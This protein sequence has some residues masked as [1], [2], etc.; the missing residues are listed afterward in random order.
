MF[1][2]ICSRSRHFLVILALKPSKPYS[3]C[4]CRILAIFET[5]HFELHH[6]FKIKRCV[7]HLTCTVPASP[8]SAAIIRSR[9]MIS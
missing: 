5:I 6:L 1:R 3:A 9:T 2:I 8:L 7:K 4:R